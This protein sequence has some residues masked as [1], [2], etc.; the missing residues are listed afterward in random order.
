[1]KK[2]D[3]SEFKPQIVLSV[4]AGIGFAIY[5]I[6][7]K[8]EPGAAIMAGFGV[9]VMAFVA[10]IFLSAM[11][12]QQDEK[13]I[14][15]DN[16]D[17]FIKEQDAI[18]KKEENNVKAQA[19]RPQNV[20][21]RVQEEASSKEKASRSVKG[22]SIVRIPK[23]YTV[24]DTETT[25][26][27]PEKD[28]LIEI[29]A[30]RVRGGKEVGRF[31]TL[32]KPGR[33]LSKKIVS[34]TNITDEMLKDAPAPE[35]CLPKFL[36]FLRDDVIVAHNANFDVD[37][38]Y[39]SLQRFGLPPLE[40]N[41][42]DTL[43]IARYVE[44][45]MDNYKLSTLA[46]EYKIPQSTA[47]RALADCETTMAVLQ[48][49]DESA[50]EQGI[51]FKQIQKRTSFSKKKAADVVQNPGIEKPENSLYKKYCTFTGELDTM[52]RLEAMQAVV[53]IGGFCRD[54]VSKKTNYLIVGTNEYGEKSASEKK[55]E[56]LVEGGLEIQTINESAFLK[57]LAE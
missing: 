17:K 4:I 40:N 22:M 54:K 15:N 25:G 55:V 31:E 8:E 27:D 12:E 10:F 51:D 9:G 6:I 34:I 32:V 42:I 11:V 35:E 20:N 28:R 53:D 56:E 2:N 47:H 39:E 36:E 16:L 29:A 7:K 18:K 52:T 44:P 19:V 46:K 41:F 14:A 30:I 26:L 13:K 48:H 5:Q 43:R 49:L 50:K 57:M 1:M 21:V 33:K 37:F 45:D 3:I 23:H 38:I 24:V